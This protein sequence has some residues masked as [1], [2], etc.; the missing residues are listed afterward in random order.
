MAPQR[1][2]GIRVGTPLAIGPWTLHAVPA[3]HEELAVD[4]NGDHK[5][6][7]LVV[8]V[9]PWTLYHSGDT[10]LYEGMVEHLQPYAIDIAM[11]PINGRDPA[12]GVAGNLSGPEAVALAQAAGIAT[13]IPCHYD[14]FAFNTVTPETFVAAAQQAGQAYRLMQNGERW[15]L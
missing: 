11:L 1:L 8:T 4:D 2:T 9:G 13:V 3:A 12:R 7:G 15:S 5:F 14:M 10:L 6:I